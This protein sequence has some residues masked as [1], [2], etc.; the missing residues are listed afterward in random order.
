MNAGGVG[1]GEKFEGLSK[2]KRQ[3]II[4][5]G[6]EVFSQNDYRR[7]STDVIAAR[8][9]ISKGLLFYYFRNKKSLYLYLFDYLKKM[10]IKLVV[11]K[12]FMEI[13]DFF[14][15][16]EYSTQKKMEIWQKHPYLLDFAMRTYFSEKEEVSPFLK[17][18]YKELEEVLYRQCFS[19][20]DT[21]KFREGCDP[22][23]V[24]KLLV[25]MSDGYLREV[26]MRGNGW[27][28]EE[29]KKEYD[30]WIRML[31]REA[32]KELYWREEDKW[33]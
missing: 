8:A 17:K 33:V 11:D 21:Y 20:V 13:T 30:G 22:F 31:R 10:L 24:L 27:D 7:A 3:R 1:M 29:I 23:H 15:L 25:W 2:E 19:H 6:F 5:A 4:N 26:N 14:E 12:K 28:M 18:T 16:L 32:Y 9:G